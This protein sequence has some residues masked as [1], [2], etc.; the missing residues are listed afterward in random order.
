MLLNVFSVNPL[1]CFRAGFYGSED[2][3]LFI[4]LFLMFTYI[5]ISKNGDTSV[6]RTIFVCLV[7]F[8]RKSCVDVCMPANRL[9]TTTWQPTWRYPTP[10]FPTLPPLPPSLPPS[11]Y[12][13][14]T[15]PVTRSLINHS[16][17]KIV[18]PRTTTRLLFKLI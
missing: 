3:C 12:L 1:D 11:P 8:T 6:R 18:T 7:N 5:A 2:V 17:A 9:A 16:I 10:S 4:P 15:H 14:S 13:L